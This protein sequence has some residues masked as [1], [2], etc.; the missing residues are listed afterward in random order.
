MSLSKYL[1]SKRDLIRHPPAS[2]SEISRQVKLSAHQRCLRGGEIINWVLF[3]WQPLNRDRPK[4]VLPRPSLVRLFLA[5]QKRF[6]LSS[7]PGLAE[8]P[9]VA[10]PKTGSVASCCRRSSPRGAGLPQPPPVGPRSHE[11][12]SRG[13]RVECRVFGARRWPVGQRRMRETRRPPRMST[14]GGPPPH[15]KHQRMR[16]SA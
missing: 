9:G 8:H 13:A 2:A 1:F 11:S 14:R 16:T 6:L 4:R 15:G 7:K 3:C 5:V 12:G 10:A